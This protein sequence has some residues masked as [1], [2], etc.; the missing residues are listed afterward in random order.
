MLRIYETILEVIRELRPFVSALERVD[1]SLAD[2]IKR[3]EQSV[4]LNSRE[5]WGS[6]KGNRRARF[7]NACGSAN[8]VEACVDC[9]LAMYEIEAPAEST[10]DKLKH[11]IGALTI[12]SR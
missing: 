8:E 4:A 11:V 12:L 10:R 3:A 7:D 6:R 9:A 2:Q 5:G 1:G